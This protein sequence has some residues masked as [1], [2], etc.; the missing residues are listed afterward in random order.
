[1]VLDP[2]RPLG[3]R[4]LLAGAVTALVAAAAAGARAAP[5]TTLR[6]GLVDSTWSGAELLRQVGAGP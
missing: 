5:R 4:T 6:R 3:R 1:M 2:A